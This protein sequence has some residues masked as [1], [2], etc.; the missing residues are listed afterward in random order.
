MASSSVNT[1]SSDSSLLSNFHRNQVKRSD[2]L[3]A[4]DDQ[5]KLPETTTMTP[6][7]TEGQLLQSTTSNKHCD[8]ISVTTTT[9]STTTSTI[10]TTT[11]KSSI[12]VLPRQRTLRTP[13][14]ARSMS[15][16]KTY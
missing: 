16:N 1:P 12:K 8:N 10:S 14:W 11:A 5:C 7:S 6:M 9:T 2:N 4:T 3:P 13:I 15:N